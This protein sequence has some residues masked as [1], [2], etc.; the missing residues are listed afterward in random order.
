MSVES[1]MQ[2]DVWYTASFICL[3]MI[4]LLNLMMVD[5]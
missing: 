1:H 3:L 4:V 5:I 2:L